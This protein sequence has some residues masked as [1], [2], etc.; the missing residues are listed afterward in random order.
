VILPKDGEAGRKKKYFCREK[1][2]WRE[3]ITLCISRQRRGLGMTKAGRDDR[4]E[5]P[6]RQT[7]SFP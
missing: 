3:M 7:A 2:T 5:A 1:F 6:S 4:G